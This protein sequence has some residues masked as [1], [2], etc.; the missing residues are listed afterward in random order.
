MK[1]L[2]AFT[3]IGPLMGSGE[4]RVTAETWSDND[5]LWVTNIINTIGKKLDNGI[6]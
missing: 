1:G 4:V 2:Q 6:T 5:R 3:F